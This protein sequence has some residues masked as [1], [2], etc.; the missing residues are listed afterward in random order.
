MI[1]EDITEVGGQPPQEGA[2]GRYK[3]K[4]HVRIVPSSEKGSSTSL[5]VAMVEVMEETVEKVVLVNFINMM[6]MSFP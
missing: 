1:N 6:K 3:G 4:E 5:Q 2:S